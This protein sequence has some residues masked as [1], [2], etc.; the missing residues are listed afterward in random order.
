MKM[1]RD[2]DAF[3]DNTQKKRNF[4][5][6][7]ENLNDLE[8][9]FMFKA[10]LQEANIQ[11]ELINHVNQKQELQSK[12]C[13]IQEFFEDWVTRSQEEIK[14]YIDNACKEK[15]KGLKKIGPPVVQSYNTD[16]INQLGPMFDSV[17]DFVE[18]VFTNQAEEPLVSEQT[19]YHPDRY[20][21]M[22]KG[23]VSIIRGN[24]ADMLARQATFSNMIKNSKY[25]RSTDAAKAPAS[26]IKGA[27]PGHEQLSQISEGDSRR[28]D[29]RT[30]ESRG[31]KGKDAKG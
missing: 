1:C 18:Q 23:E 26:P 25:N 28:S 8:K 21:K 13:K 16:I 17:V 10:I 11:N 4:D 29:S 7:D 20:A 31:G 27:A 15:F 30:I 24:F 3:G 5:Q 12:L 2:I 14:E 6:I 22:D 19:G 9:Q